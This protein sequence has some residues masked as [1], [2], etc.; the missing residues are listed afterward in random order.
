MPELSKTW[1]YPAALGLMA[2]AVV[3]LYRFFK[4]IDWL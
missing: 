1:A 4:R 2:V 3:S